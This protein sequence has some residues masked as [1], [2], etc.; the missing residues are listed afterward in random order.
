MARWKFIVS[1]MPSLD[2]AGLESV[3]LSDMAM[4]RRIVRKQDIRILPWVC[5]TY[6]LSKPPYPSQLTV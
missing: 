2:V 1:P 4:E 6:L 3:D 5:L